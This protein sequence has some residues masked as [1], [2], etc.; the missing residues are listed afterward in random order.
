MFQES[1]ALFIYAVSPVHMGAG[2][3]FGLIDNPI[4]RERHTDYPLLAGSGLKGAVRHRWWSQLDETARKDSQS[5]LNRLF[6]PESKAADHAGA[7]SFSDAQLVA[8]PVRSLKGAFV[9]ATSPTALA[10]AQRALDVAGVAAGWTIP[11]VDA[12]HCQIA[13]PDLLYDDKLALEAFEF[14]AQCSKE[15]RIISEWLAENAL[16]EGDAHHFFRGKLR[17]D[18]V[19]LSDEDFGYFARNATVVEPH[20]RIDDASGTAADTGL[21]YTENLPPESLMLGLAMASQERSRNG[22]GLGAAQVMSKLIEG[23]D[24]F[25]GLDGAL[26]QVGGD[27]TAGRGQ[28]VLKALGGKSDG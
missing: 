4:Q 10:R 2:T 21:F 14:S 24:G 11:K 9:Y 25:D 12:G 23:G 28:V 5:L 15:L 18:L 3:A 8:F 22:A 6:G 17:D 13:N 27:A 26:V 7:V 19:L 20:V 1:R 16:P